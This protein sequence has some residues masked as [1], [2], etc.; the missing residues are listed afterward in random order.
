MSRAI[1]EHHQ[2]NDDET[3]VDM[4]V[5]EVKAKGPFTIQR[6]DVDV[7]WDTDRKGIT[8]TASY[9]KT[10]TIPLL[11]KKWILRF[12]PTAKERFDF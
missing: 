11:N 8:V 6:K 4:V 12:N 7:L 3:I 5:T 10:I 1:V 2:A 9:Y